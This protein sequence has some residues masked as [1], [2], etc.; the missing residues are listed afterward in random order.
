MAM[1]LMVKNKLGLFDGTIKK[2]SEDRPESCNNGTDATIWSRHG[3]W[4]RCQR[5]FQEALSTV[6][7][8]DKCGLTYKKACSCETKKEITYYVETLKTIK[9]LMGLNDSYAKFRSNTLFLGPLSTVNKA[10]SLVFH[11]E[12]QEEVSS[13]KGAAQPKAAVFVMKTTSREAEF[14]YNGPQCGKCNKTNHTTKNCPA[15][16]KCTSLNIHWLSLWSKGL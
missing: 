9:F 7:M 12:R 6:R 15:Y 13:G 4:G 2:P 8:L 11:H 5:K 10:Y 3:Y 14:E 1:A 16:L